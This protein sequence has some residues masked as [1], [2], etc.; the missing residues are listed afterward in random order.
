MPALSRIISI[1]KDCYVPHIQELLFS[2]LFSSFSGHVFPSCT[3]PFIVEEPRRT[4]KGFRA[5]MR[6]RT[7]SLSPVSRKNLRDGN[8]LNRQKLT[9]SR[10]QFNE[11]FSTC[12]YLLTNT[13]SIIFALIHLPIL[14]SIP[15]QTSNIKY[16]NI[17]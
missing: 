11:D 8:Y 16:L 13:S 4:L 15:I 1:D 5:R 14:K 6:A 3:S 9:F 17:R 2:S 10:Q 12:C 7:H